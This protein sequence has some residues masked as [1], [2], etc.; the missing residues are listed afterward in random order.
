MA[1]TQENVGK[2]IQLAV[3]ADDVA[4]SRPMQLTGLDKVI[5]LYPTLDEALTALGRAPATSGYG[6]STWRAIA[7]LCTS[8][9]PS[10]SRKARMSEKII[11]TGVSSE[12]PMPPR[13]W[14]QRSATLNSSSDT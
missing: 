8:V 14:T 5:S 11:P 6:R 12:M 2:S 10:Y 3:V 4:T 9:G 1:A 13:I 7:Y